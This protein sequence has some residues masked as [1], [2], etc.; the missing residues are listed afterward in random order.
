MIDRYEMALL[1][2]GLKDLLPPESDHE[3]MIGEALLERI[4]H[5]GYERVKP[6]LVEFEDGLLSGVG[7]GLEGQTFRL[8]DPVSDRM[9]A[10]R[11]DVTPQV[12][13]IATT[14]LSKSPRPLRLSYSADIMRIRG[15]ELRPERQF[16]QVGYELISPSSIVG[17]T[18][19]LLLAVDCLK[20]IGVSNLSVDLNTPTLVTAILDELSLNEPELLL[21]RNMLD[22]KDESGVRKLAGS[23][24]DSLVALFGAVGSVNPALEHLSKIKLPPIARQ[25]AENLE[26]VASLVISGEPNLTLTVDPVERRSFEYHT[27]VSF[28]LFARGVRGELGRGGRYDIGSA[29]DSESS[30]GCTLYLDTLMRAVPSEAKTNKLFIPVDVSRDIS[31]KLREDGWITVQ[32]LSQ[33]DDTKKEAQRL[34]CSH[35]FLNNKVILI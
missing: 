21:L 17:D 13:R 12:A 27:G 7:A 1:P 24:A 30:T 25:Q 8:M 22:R 33:V 32:G 6:P 18:E 23:A 35:I 34:S 4:S 9:M 16:C 20:S 15:N 19:V 14:R 3:A 11:S 5:Y 29:Q 10:L 2:A 28:T 31:K 26:K